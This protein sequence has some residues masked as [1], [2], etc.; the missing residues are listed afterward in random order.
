M[1]K[2]LNRLF[3]NI[4]V[5]HQTTGHLCF[6]ARHRHVLHFHIVWGNH[7]I[8]FLKIFECCFEN[9][10]LVIHLMVHNDRVKVAYSLNKTYKNNCSPLK[11][12]CSFC[13]L[14][15]HIICT[16]S[17]CYSIKISTNIY[18]QYNGSWKFL[19]IFFYMYLILVWD[20]WG[21]NVRGRL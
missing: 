19:Y 2:D 6:C 18:M 20:S 8:V 9:Q 17:P 11:T 3:L 14:N 12:Q 7:W 4:G 13:T 15:R 1:C 5:C 21:I 16:I 10:L